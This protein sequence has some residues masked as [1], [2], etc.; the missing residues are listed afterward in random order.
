M[1]FITKKGINYFSSSAQ[2]TKWLNLRLDRKIVSETSKKLMGGLWVGGTCELHTDRLLVYGNKLN[3]SIHEDLETL[4]IPLNA[5]D[6]VSLDKKI[7]TDIIVI[8][9]GGTEVNFRCFGADKFMRTINE[10]IE[11]SK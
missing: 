5:I 11:T 2:V 7:T 9:F 3:R 10:A 8:Q 4:E 6:G 1:S